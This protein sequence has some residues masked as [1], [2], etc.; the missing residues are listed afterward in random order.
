M[1]SGPQMDVISV[2]TEREERWAYERH[3]DD[4]LTVR[5]ISDLSTRHPDDGGLGYYLSFSTVSR[6]WR[7]YRTKL[8]DVEQDKREERVHTHEER[9]DRNERFALELSGPIDHAATAKKRAMAKANGIDP[10]DPAL[11]VLRDEAVRLRAIAEL[12][13][14]TESRRK[15]RG[16]DAPV[17]HKLDVTVIDAATAELNAMLAEVGLDPIPESETRS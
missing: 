4:G 2:R 16:D 6:R 10:N 8:L 9:L 15:L 13:R 7:T 3:V 14:I 17:E 5:A 12:T 1:S 11:V